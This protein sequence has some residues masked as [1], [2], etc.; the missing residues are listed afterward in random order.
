MTA[1][2]II[3]PKYEASALLIVNTAPS[4]TTTMTYEDVTLSQDL[5]ST[6]SIIMTNPTLMGKVIS[7]LGLSITPEALAKEITVAGVNTTQVL[8][9]TV[10]DTNAERA[11]LIANEIIQVAPTEIMRTVKAGSVEIISPA[12][13]ENKPVSPNKML[14]T[15]IGLLA[16]L[17]ISLA[18]AFIGELFNNKF[19][20]DEDVQ[21][22]LGMSVIG[23]IPD[24]TKLE[25][26]S[27]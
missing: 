20:T 26:R 15:A 12:K 24:I 8:N 25:K 18:I 27:N 16:G 11:K 3:K 17:V 22:T 5:V 14:Y 6:Y 1:T 21:K 19:S 7:D 10:T 13:S 9:L 4:T 2:F 23:I